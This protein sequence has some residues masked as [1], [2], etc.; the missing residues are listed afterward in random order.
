M[1]KL[2]RDLLYDDRI[3]YVIIATKTGRMYYVGKHI[4]TFIIVL[5]LEMLAVIHTNVQSIINN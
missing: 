2:M 5:D 3:Y 4:C 1:L